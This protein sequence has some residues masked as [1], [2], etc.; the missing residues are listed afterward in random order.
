MFPTEFKQGVY[1]ENVYNLNQRNKKQM[2]C[3]LW[4]EM[5]NDPFYNRYEKQPL[6]K[7][8]R[9]FVLATTRIP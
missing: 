3:N 7:I 1:K 4:L 9:L 2:F 8:G 5:R 6:I